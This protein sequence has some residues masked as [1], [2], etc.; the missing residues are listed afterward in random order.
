[1]TLQTVS[2][3]KRNHQKSEKFKLYQIKL[4]TQ[5]FNTFSVY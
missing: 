4:K 5:I 3:E 2:S 1:M